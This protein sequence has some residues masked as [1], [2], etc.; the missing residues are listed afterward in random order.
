MGFGIRTLSCIVLLSLCNVVRADEPVG[1]AS[2]AGIVIGTYQAASRS[3]VNGAEVQGEGNAQALLEVELPLP[4]GSWHL[5]IRGGTTPADNGVTATFGEANA[6]VGETLDQQGDGRIALTQLFYN[7][8]LWRGT[9]ST[10]LIDPTA[11][12]DTN[13]VANSEYTQFL[14]TGFVNNPA[15]DFP[16]F[17]LAATYGSQ[18]T[19]GL[20]YRL[21]VSSSSGLQDASDPTYPNVFSPG[22]DGKGVFVA[23]ELAWQGAGWQG[24]VGSWGN[25][26]DHPQLDNPAHNGASYGVYANIVGRLHAGQWHVRLG[27]ARAA[28]SPAANFVSAAVSYP[29][30][31]VVLGVGLSRTG[32]SSRQPRPRASV[33]QAEL[34]ARLPLIKG[35]YLSPDIQYLSHSGFNPDNGHVWIGGL[36][37]SATF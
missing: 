29:I 4:P 36:R 33:V 34:Y 8:R 10:G 1:K 7:V 25:T 3:A 14:G 30:G 11:F 12:L 16:S 31:R 2:I 27:V 21:F 13:V 15:I 20:G 37:A 18:L 6:T 24:H 19:Q 17:V 32:V 28:V 26:S 22:G 9:L 35:F 23:A 5:E